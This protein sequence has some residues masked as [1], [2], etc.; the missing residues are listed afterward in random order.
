M[1]NQNDIRWIKIIS[2]DG[3]LRKQDFLCKSNYQLSVGY[4]PFHRCHRIFVYDASVEKYFQLQGFPTGDLSTRSA[5]QQQQEF[6]TSFG[7]KAT[8]WIQPINNSPI[9]SRVRIIHTTSLM[10]FKKK[11]LWL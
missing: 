7:R 8:K 9:D 3:C 4:K 10:K 11:I 5:K 1:I 2:Q 6:E